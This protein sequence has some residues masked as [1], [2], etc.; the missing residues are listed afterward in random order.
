M[1]VVQ[2]N[3]E[4]KEE[5]ERKKSFININN[6]TNNEKSVINIKNLTNNVTI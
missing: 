6:L 4:N 2:I 5:N 3:D 1:S